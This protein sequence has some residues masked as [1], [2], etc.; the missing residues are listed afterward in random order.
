MILGELDLVFSIGFGVFLIALIS[1]VDLFT[2]LIIETLGFFLNFIYSIVLFS[3]I[4][5][6]G[7][8]F[9]VSPFYLVLNAWNLGFFRPI[10]WAQCRQLQMG[11]KGEEFWW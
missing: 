3:L 1:D 7:W 6:I 4:Y 2:E 11:D 8:K 10:A 5:S 9:I